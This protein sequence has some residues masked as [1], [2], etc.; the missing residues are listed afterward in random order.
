[1]YLA[2]ISCQHYISYIAATCVCFL[3]SAV[4]IIMSFIL[5]QSAYVSSCVQIF[6]LCQLHCNE[7]YMYLAVLSFQ[8][9]FSYIAATCVCILI[10]VV[11]NIMSVILRVMCIYPCFSGVLKIELCTL[12]YASNWLF[13]HITIVET[14][15][16]CRRGMKPVAITIINPRNDYW[17]SRGSNQRPLF[18]SS[19]WYRLSYDIGRYL[20]LQKH[21]IPSFSRA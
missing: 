4:F 10:S 12:F 20:F 13:S 17:P 14:T 7:V 16:S 19:V 6:T 18:L 3:L 2:V 1:M 8:H 11:F 9:C 15:D 21:Y 5:R